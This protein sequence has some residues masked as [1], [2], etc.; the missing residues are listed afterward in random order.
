[1]V[2]GYLT[3]AAACLAAWRSAP[4]G[5]GTTLRFAWLVL[6]VGLVGLAVNKE[7]DLHRILIGWVRSWTEPDNVRGFRVVIGASTVLA[8]GVA[9]FAW[10]R[11]GPR[12]T[13][14]ITRSPQLRSAILTFG[15]LVVMLG[16]RVAPGPVSKF[17]VTHILTE[18][19]N[20]W[21]IHLSELLEIVAAVII[22]RC[23]WR[24]RLGNVRPSTSPSP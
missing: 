7:L 8:C 6:A 14:A 3:A 13:A 16:L 18:E 24:F 23:A 2:A 9:L 10:L 5:T 20:L 15:L 1:M 22:A 17:L 19:D 12:L 11:Y 21:H 4:A